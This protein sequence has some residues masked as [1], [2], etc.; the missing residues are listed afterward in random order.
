MIRTL[1]PSLKCRQRLDLVVLKKK[2]VQQKPPVGKM[3]MMVDVGTPEVRRA[4]PRKKVAA[5]K[6]GCCKVPSD[7]FFLSMQSHTSEPLLP[8]FLP[9]TA[10]NP[11]SFS[12]LLAPIAE[13]FKVS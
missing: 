9:S 12:S 8:S 7:T 2:F 6:G 10:L 5:R 1:N 13:S 3:M 4:I 11:F